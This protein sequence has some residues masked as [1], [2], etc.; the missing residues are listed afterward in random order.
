MLPPFAR[1]WAY[2]LWFGVKR[3]RSAAVVAEDVD[4]WLRCHDD[5][6]LFE[7]DEYTRFTFL[8]LAFPHFRT[9]VHYR[10]R[11]APLTLRRVL[12]SLYPPDPTLSVA[13][14]RIGP[15]LFIQ[16]GFATVVN[17]ESIGSHCWINQQVT[18]GYSNKGRPTLGDRVRV[19]A[20]AVVIGRVTL[21]DGA[22]VGANAT[23]VHDVGPDTT[24]V[25][26]VAVE[27]ERGSEHADAPKT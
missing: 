20:G 21:H 19:H 25:A 24:V 17:A 11:S 16:H 2:P 14:D 1:A 7:L 27:L 4:W 8:A 15:G 26:P 3:A 5:A 6:E 22:V 10:L 13:A 18:I 23:V 9:V 12:R